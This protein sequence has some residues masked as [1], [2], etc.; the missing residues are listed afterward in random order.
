MPDLGYR[1]VE[2]PYARIRR[3]LDTRNGEIV[4]FVYQLEYDVEASEDGLP[5]HDW[6]E[7][8]RFDHSI[9]NP[10]GHDVGEEGL[11]L[12]VYRNG[13]K[14]RTARGFPPLR[15]TQA[16]RFC[17]QFLIDRADELLARFEKWH[18][19]GKKWA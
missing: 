10:M 17:E 1:W 7:V 13:K 16:P 11:H 2:W 5:P 4:R 15:P 18:D 6:Q 14:Y 19:V 12:D 3:E 9:E 8:A